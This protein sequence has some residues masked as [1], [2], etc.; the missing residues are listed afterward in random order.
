MTL[1]VLTWCFSVESAL[2][3]VQGPGAA[4]RLLVT[5]DAA[6]RAPGLALGLRALQEVGLG[7]GIGGGTTRFPDPL[8]A[9]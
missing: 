2:A 4:P 3:P 7:A 8:E 5:A 6:G 9:R 1:Q